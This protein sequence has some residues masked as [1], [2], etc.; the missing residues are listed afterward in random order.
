VASGKFEIVTGVEHDEFAQ[1]KIAASNDELV[2]E[3]ETVAELL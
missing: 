2:G 1:A 3:R